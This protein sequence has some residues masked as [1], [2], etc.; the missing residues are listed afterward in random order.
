LPPEIAV[1][2]PVRIEG[3]P[4][5]DLVAVLDAP[6]IETS[7]V[8]TG[9]AQLVLGGTSLQPLDD[10][11]V[12][13]VDLL[14]ER[15]GE[16]RIGV[17]HEGVRF[18][19]WTS[20]KTL[21]AALATEQRI[22]VP[23]VAAFVVDA[24]PELV[25]RAGA[26]VMTLEHGREHTR[27]RYVGVLEVEGMV[28]T[29]A[30]ATRGAPGRIVRRTLKG[31][32]PLLVTPGAN[33]RAEPRWGAPVLARVTYS[34]TIGIVKALDDGWYEVSFDDHDVRVHGFV[35]RKDPPG[36]VHAKRSAEVLARPAAPNRVPGGVCLYASGEVVGLVHGAAFG[37]L[38]P[39]ERPGWFT[40][41]VDTPWDTIDF[42][43]RG[44][45]ENDLAP[46]ASSSP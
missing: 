35:S 7:W 36:A 3:A 2:H 25:L 26:R 43:V 41:T 46:C 33:I 19:I 12:L 1:A 29:A 39:Q 32:R 34:T 4:P 21:Q 10:E 9:P 22:A 11:K 16:V 30:L 42:D 37:S 38:V 45:T 23:G 17:R 20:R 27:V 6:Q 24:A 40:F 28:P 15:G 13:E 18:A 31:Q 44:A 8:R 14:E 5:V